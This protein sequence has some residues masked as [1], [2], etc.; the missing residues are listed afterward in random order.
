MS[1][2]VG[3]KKPKRNQL[4]SGTAL[5]RTHWPACEELAD[6]RALRKKGLSTTGLVGDIEIS[7]CQIEDL[8]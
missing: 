5:K 2:V 3:E 1:A 4:F 7:S 6:V 8:D